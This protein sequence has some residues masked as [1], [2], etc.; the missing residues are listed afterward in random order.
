MR[1][2]ASHGDGD[3]SQHEAH[4]HPHADGIAG[5]EQ[6]EPVVDRRKDVC[7]VHPQPG[8]G[9]DEAGGYEQVATGEAMP[10]DVAAPERRRELEGADE[11]VDQRADDVGEDRERIVREAIGSGGIAHGDAADADGTG[12]RRHQCQHEEAG[13][14]PP[15]A[16]GDAGFRGRGTGSGRAGRRGHAAMLARPPGPRIGRPAGSGAR[17]HPVGHR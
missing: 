16:G 4:E 2:E 12:D 6:H 13:D 8:Q 10:H 11:R 9:D 1:L 7:R 5:Q 14:E 3:E 15:L 17:A